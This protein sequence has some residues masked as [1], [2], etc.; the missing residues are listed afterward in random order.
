VNPLKRI[1]LSLIENE[2]PISVERYM[3]MCL[4]HPGHGYYMTRDPLGAN[5]DFITAPEISQMF[6]EL[7]GLWLA[8]VW[9]DLG[10]PP[11]MRIVECG[12]GRGTLLL[13]ALRAAAT[14]PGLREALCL[15][16]VETSPVLKATQL[17]NLSGMDISVA[18]HDS[19]ETVATDRPIVLFA[20]EFLDALPIRQYQAQNGSWHERLIGANG[21]ELTFGLS[22]SPEKSIRQT[23]NEGA[24]LE[25]SPAI[26]AF[27]KTLSQKL[28]AASG[29]ALLIDYGHARSALGD[30]LQAMVRHGFVDPLS[31]P[32]EADL[33]A[34]VDF[35]AIVKAARESNLESYGPIEQ[36][37]F[38]RNLGLQVRAEMLIEKTRD[39]AQ[40]ESIASAERRLTDM[41]L[42]GMGRLFKVISLV[43]PGQPAPPAF[44][45]ETSRS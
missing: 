7:I 13:D 34:H 14:V 20:N 30:T 38:L 5:G 40:R 17:R 10:S 43:A 15:D 11:A 1:L 3:T 19:L 33:T 31:D 22:V 2:G 25:I 32:G 37:L 4:G 39:P 28:K 44:L 6:G 18:W 16:L 8:Q 41:S 35:G 9:L 36:G 23:A 12:P 45:P 42:A 24:V 29:V 21:D 26:Q 27:I